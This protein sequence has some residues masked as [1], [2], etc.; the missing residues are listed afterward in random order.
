M[1]SLLTSRLYDHTTFYKVFEKD[2]KRA[3]R[4]VLIESPFITERRMNELLP[5][6]I[7]LRNRGILIVINTRNPAEHEVAYQRQA[8]SAVRVMQ[9]LGIMVL[10]TG[11]HHRKIAII[12][13]EILWEGSLNILSQSDSC[14]IMRRTESRQLV[15]EMARFIRVSQWL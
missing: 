1:N 9:K 7:R 11:K 3:R 10:Y 2:L 13:G 12:D 15:T 14:E 6:L 5:L 4:S 8:A